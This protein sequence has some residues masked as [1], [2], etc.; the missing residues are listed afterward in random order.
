MGLLP[1]KVIRF[2]NWHNPVSFTVALGVDSASNRKEYQESS[3]WGGGEGGGNGQ[4]AHKHLS[5]I[6]ELSVLE[7]MVAWTF[8]NPEG[9]HS[10]LQG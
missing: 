2:L 8:H 3:G 7:N 6:C 5:T 9:L 4:P 10:L 1:D